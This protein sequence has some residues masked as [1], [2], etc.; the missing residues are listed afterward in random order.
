MNQLALAVVF[1]MSLMANSPAM[2]GECPYEILLASWQQVEESAGKSAEMLMPPSV[3]M[4]VEHITVCRN[5][6][7]VFLQGRAGS[8]SFA[9]RFIRANQ[10]SFQ[11]VLRSRF[12][13]EERVSFE[14]DDERPSL[15][16]DAEG[17]VMLEWKGQATEIVGERYLYVSPSF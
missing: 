7:A 5:G 6:A 15:T 4:T 10:N 14:G 12:A 13:I 3:R 11:D 16:T 8:T 9:V 17:R 2:A 1:A